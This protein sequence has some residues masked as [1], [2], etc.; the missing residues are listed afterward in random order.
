MKPYLF[1]IILI[2]VFFINP[3]KL[4]CALTDT[5]S[6]YK[7][8]IKYIVI[9]FPFRWQSY[10]IVLDTMAKNGKT[11]WN[12][13]AQVKSLATFDANNKNLGLVKIGVK[14]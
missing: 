7:E 3:E 5:M 4:L 2:E 6:P 11:A 1:C 8:R 14:S 12:F 10:V 9:I 13:A